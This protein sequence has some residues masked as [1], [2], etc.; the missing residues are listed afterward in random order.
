MNL[1]IRQASEDEIEDLI[2]LTLLAFKPIFKSFAQ[3]LGPEI[4]PILYPDWKAAQ[5]KVVVSELSNEE[6]TVWLGELNGKVVGLIT[7]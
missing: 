3:I 5:T 1:T 2:D 4:F 6:I 7:Q